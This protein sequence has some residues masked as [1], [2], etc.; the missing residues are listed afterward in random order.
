[1]DFYYIRICNMDVPI[2][3]AINP[4]FIFPI[5]GYSKTNHLLSNQLLLCL[6]PGLPGLRMLPGCT[7]NRRSQ[8]SPIKV[9]T[10]FPWG[11][12]AIL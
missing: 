12:D 1:M 3:W 2:P 10:R 6:L 7:A 8:A 11:K 5:T 9:E 4:H